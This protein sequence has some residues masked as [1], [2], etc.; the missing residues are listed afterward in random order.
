[1]QNTIAILL[2]GQNILTF[3]LFCVLYKHKTLISDG[4]KSSLVEKFQKLQGQNVLKL[5]QFPLH[6]LLQALLYSSPY[7]MCQAQVEGFGPGALQTA[8]RYVAHFV[9][10]CHQ[11]LTAADLTSLKNPLSP[12][13]PHTVICE[14][15]AEAL[16][17][18]EVVE[19]YSFIIIYVVP[20]STE[21]I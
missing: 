18:T 15:H 16:S 1:M 6:I 7:Q 19:L 21:K 11:L 9:Q 8:D 20:D 10:K 17:R 13:L 14:R 4:I 12:L 2:Q 3:F 5:L